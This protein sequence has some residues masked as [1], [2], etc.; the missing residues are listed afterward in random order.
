M[1]T[2]AA[3]TATAEAQVAA[4]ATAAFQVTATL[5][6]GLTATAEAQEAASFPAGPTP[7][8]AVAAPNG[9]VIL[10]S[11]P[12]PDYDQVASLSNGTRL[13]VQRRVSGKADWIKV[14]INAGSTD[15]LAGYV[16]LASDLIRVNV[17]L[18]DLPLIYEFGP[19]LYEP[20]RFETRAVEALITFKWQDYGEL[21]ADQFYSIILVRDDLSDAESCF[22]WQTKEPEVAFKPANYGCTPGDYHWGVGL[23]TKIGEKDGEIIWR[24]DSEFDERSPI[25]IGVPHSGRPS[26]GDDGGGGG[27]GGSDSIEG[28]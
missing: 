14:E 10:R 8:A 13:N 4:T 20:P 23:A 22:H 25:G 18:D 17:S 11:G 6:A 3:A 26:N 15:S 2:M 1:A 7:D 24:D 12:G 19:A 28:G 9:V 27:H 16:N 5:V 21:A